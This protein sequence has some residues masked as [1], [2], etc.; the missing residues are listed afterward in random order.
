MKKRST[1]RALWG[2]VSSSGIRAACWKRQRRPPRLALH[3]Y[4]VMYMLK[5]PTTLFAPCV[6]VAVLFRKKAA[7][8]TRD[9]RLA[10]STQPSD[11]EDR[12]AALALV[13][14]AQW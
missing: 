5:P 8:P 10:L 7:P 11:V 12:V 3:F 14:K 9:E 13:E 4:H 1:P 6:P 2:S